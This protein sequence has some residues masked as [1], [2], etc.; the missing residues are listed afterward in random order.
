MTQFGPTRLDELGNNMHMTDFPEID[1]VP[2]ADRRALF[3]ENAVVNRTLERLERDRFV[4]W[5]V[6]RGVVSR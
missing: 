2:E 5:R 1:D 4:L 3:L 6:F